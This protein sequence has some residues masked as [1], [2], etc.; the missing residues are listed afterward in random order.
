MAPPKVVHPVAD[1]SSSKISAF[2]TAVVIPRLSA[3][4]H[5]GEGLTGEG[6]DVRDVGNADGKYEDHI[7]Q[8]RKNLPAFSQTL[9]WTVPED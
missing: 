8:L 1:T 2:F 7:D 4:N 9:P 5:S 3:A 6:I